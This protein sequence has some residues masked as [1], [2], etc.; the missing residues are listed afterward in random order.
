[1]SYTLMLATLDFGKTFIV[2]CDASGWGIR[3]VLVQESLV[4][5]GK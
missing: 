3:A 2:E 5:S 4:E 1:M